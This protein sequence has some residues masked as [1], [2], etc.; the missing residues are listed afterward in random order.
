MCLSA[1]Q[2]FTALREDS[3][4]FTA[5]VQTTAAKATAAEADLARTI[6]ITGGLANV[7]RKTMKNEQ[8][9]I[10]AANKQTI[11]TMRNIDGLVSRANGLVVTS[12]DALTS[13]SSDVHNT[14]VA[15]QATI[16]ASTQTVQDV[17]KLV[18]D[19][20]IATAITQLGTASTEIAE[21]SAHANKILKDGQVVA[22]HYTAEILKP[23]SF[24]KRAAEYLLSF[25][26]DARVLFSSK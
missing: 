11:T 15:V 17:D 12:G 14:A 3:A 25:G 18:S 26:S 2:L 19:P 10:T 7:F 6:E 8:A 13:A 22:D 20:Q 1:A 24:V 21:A 16:A 9:T 5:S 23:V 4:K